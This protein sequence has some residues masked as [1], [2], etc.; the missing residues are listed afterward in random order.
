[1]I[2]TFLLLP[3]AVSVTILPLGDSITRGCDDPYDIDRSG[4]RI[5]LQDRLRAAGIPYDMVGDVTDKCHPA[6]YDWDNAG[7]ASY[8]VDQIAEMAELLIPRYNPEMVLLLAGTN[9]HWDPPNRD[10]FYQQYSHLLDVLGDRPIY[11]ATVPKFGYGTPPD[12][13]YWTRD[14]VDERNNVRL[15]LMNQVIHDLASER[16]NVVV[17]EYFDAL[18]PAIHLVADQV[19]PNAAGQRLLSDL[20]W[21]A[22]FGSDFNRNGLL[23]ADDIDL[24]VGQV[25]A[26]SPDP[27]FDI[28]RDGLVDLGDHQTWVRQFK[29][30][31]IGDANLDRRFDSSDMVA[32]FV[33]GKYETGT[34]AGW[35]EGDWNGDRV[36]GTTDLVS[37]F[38]D[39]GYEAISASPRAI[40]PEPAGGL[41]AGIGAFLAQWMFRRHAD[42]D[43]ACR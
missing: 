3:F 9:N 27:A 37:A 19:H 10:Q 1:M 36:F 4:Y 32:V 38:Q 43:R 17:V 30:T 8:N 21:N 18:D 14:F 29:K 23:D 31:T 33:V 40:V 39:G 6:G 15:P 41:L 7:Y 22:A 34:A 28:N 2:S 5:L 26:A 24:L 11:V 16:D 20:F 13:T 42:V 35:A 25:W 12:L